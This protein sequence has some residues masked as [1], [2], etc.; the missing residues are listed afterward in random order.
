L[1]GAE[2]IDNV[3]K[4]NARAAM[5]CN[6]DIATQLDAGPPEGAIKALEPYEDEFQRPRIRLFWS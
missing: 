5:I 1:G 2:D 4:M 6:G 3:Q